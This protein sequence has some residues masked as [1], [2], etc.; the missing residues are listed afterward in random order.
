M[1]QLIE[2]VCR[3]EDLTDTELEVALSRAVDGDASPVELAGLLIGLKAKG[4]TPAEI[5]GAARALR[6]AALPFDRPSYPFVDCCGTGG[7]GQGTPNLSTAAAFV[8][9]AAG[10]PVAK[11]GNRAVSSHCGSADVLEAL[12][13]RLELAGPQ[14]RRTLDET[15]FCFLFAPHFH[16]GMRHVMPVR[17]ALGTRTLFNLVGPL[18]NP[19]RPPLQLLGVYAPELVRPCAETLGRL[20]V[21]RALVVHGSGIDEIA[22][23]GPTRVALLE[24]GQVREETWT[25]E[26]LGAEPAPL[27][28]GSLSP[29]DSAR[30]MR[31]L[32]AGQGSRADSHSVA[33]NAG[34]MLW[35]AGLAETPCEGTRR[36]LEL[37]A[38]GTPLDT[39]ER[40]VEFSRA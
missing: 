8:A 7:D 27:A 34:A 29:V 22:L 16:R 23:H 4:E 6:R 30:W 11:H 31:A 33:V 32:L 2:R 20:G 36:A 19:S 35:L 14:A 24:R 40:Y 37:L 13:A 26:E 17:R 39:L 9:A 18:V 21:E 28:G 15:G 38:S 3:G 10:V 5:A 12:G 25:P 1:R